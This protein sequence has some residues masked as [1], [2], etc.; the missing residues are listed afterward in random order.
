M[1]RFVHGDT[2]L[3]A[4]GDNGGLSSLTVT[5]QIIS[6]LE[7][8]LAADGAAPRPHIGIHIADVRV[9]NREIQQ[10]LD[11]LAVY[12]DVLEH[13]ESRAISLEI[14]FYRGGTHFAWSQLFAEVISIESD[15][16]ACYLAQFEFPETSSKV[17]FGDSTR[18]ETI[19]VVEEI[20]AERLVDHLFI[21]GDYHAPSV[22]N[23]FLA[24]SPLVRVG[25]VIGFHDSYHPRGG[26][27]TFLAQLARGEVSGWLATDIY[28]INLHRG[29][30]ATGISYVYKA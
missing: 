16:R 9:V 30:D 2:E 19:A 3:R 5:E 22:R 8:W 6:R 26:V 29:Q 10:H 28:D 20:L 14:G 7:E 15:Y 27:G 18:P 25:G 23:Y 1:M 13:M 11:E 12:L 21:D 4:G 24:Y 17:V